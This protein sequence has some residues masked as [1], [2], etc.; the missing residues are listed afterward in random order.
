GYV[1]PAV[2]AQAA[3]VQIGEEVLRH[4]R[5]RRRAIP[6]AERMVVGR[7]RGDPEALARARLRASSEGLSVLC[8]TAD[9]AAPPSE[10]SRLRWAQLDPALLERSR[11]ASRFFETRAAQIA[12]AARV[13]AVRP[14]GRAYCGMD[15]S[16]IN[17]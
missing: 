13:N 16:G 6:Q 11:R 17:T 7:D 12:H 14:T 5:V 2:G 9:G 15:I 1:G 8:A 10:V 3:A 4:P